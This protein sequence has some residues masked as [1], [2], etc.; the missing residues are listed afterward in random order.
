MKRYAIV[1]SWIALVLLFF[2]ADGL[3]LD[4]NVRGRAE[5]SFVLRDT[6]GFQYGI[7]DEAEGVQWRNTVKV[8]NTLRPEFAGMPSSRLEQVFLSYRGA[9]DA[10]FELTDRYDAVREAP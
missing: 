2:P 9:Y 1:I 10:I 7:L 5:S 8:D 4:V 3:C 6:N